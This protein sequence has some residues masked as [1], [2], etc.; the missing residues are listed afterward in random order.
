MYYFSKIIYSTPIVGA[1]QRVRTLRVFHQVYCYLSGRYSQDF[2]ARQLDVEQQRRKHL[3][4]R[5]QMNVTRTER[6][7]KTLNNSANT[8]FRNVPAKKTLRFMRKKK[9]KK[10]I[11]FGE[12]MTR[13]HR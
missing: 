5:S 13:G 8:P 10:S 12:F 4:F 7:D 9:K 1:Y 11:I 3:E 6:T 2:Q